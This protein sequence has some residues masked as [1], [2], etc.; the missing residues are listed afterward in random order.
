MIMT[1]ILVT[2]LLS[3][4]GVLIVVFMFILKK[5]NVASDL[6]IH[7]NTVDIKENREKIAAL[8]VAVE[9]IGTTQHI[10]DENIREIKGDVKT[11]LG[12]NVA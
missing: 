7:K 5:N 12:R 2:V 1:E 6:A 3:L 8:T 9:R 4:I 10:M 11:L